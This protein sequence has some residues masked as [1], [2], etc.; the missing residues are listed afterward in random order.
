MKAAR[1]WGQRLLGL[2]FVAL[3]GACE[4][5]VSSDLGEVGC[6]AANNGAIGPPVCPENQM[7]LGSKCT[8]CEGGRCVVGGAGSAGAQG[9]QADQSAGGSDGG[10]GGAGGEAGAGGQPQGVVGG[11][12]GSAGQG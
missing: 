7:C 11:Q 3:L 6:P 9:N 1:R 4:L 8:P 10:S 5:I 2:G 12:A